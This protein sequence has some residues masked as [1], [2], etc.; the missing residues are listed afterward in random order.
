MK[1]TIEN[2]Y[3]RVVKATGEETDW[4]FSFLAF[5]D[6]QAEQKERMGFGK[7]YGKRKRDTKIRLYDRKAMRFPTGLLPILLA[8]AERRGFAVQTV[9]GRGSPHATFTELAD[10][11]FGMS[12]KWSFQLKALEAWA[13]GGD[14]NLVEKPLPFRGIVKS[15][16][17][18]GK[19]RIAVASAR[20]VEGHTL[21]MVHRGHLA[22][23]VRDRW[24]S[25]CT[26]LGEPHAGFIGDGEWR[27]GERL[28]CATLQT[29][30]RN[31]NIERYAKLVESVTSVVVDECHT[32]PAE[33]FYATIQDFDN[34]RTR[35]G[36][37]GTPYDRGDKRS[38]I[39]VA[40][41]GPMV[42]KIGA[43]QLIDLGVLSEPK[44]VVVP[45]W[46]E[47][48][49]RFRGDWNP[50]YRELVVESLHRNG[51]ILACM[52]KALADGDT[53][54]MVFV[55]RVGHAREL[56]KHAEKLGLNC[57][58]VDG[59]KDSKQRQDALRRL[60]A[61][62]LDFIVATKV[63]AEGVNIPELRCVINGAGGKSV[64]EVLQQVGRGTRTT[65]TKSSFVV[66]EVGDKGD[67]IMHKHARARVA[68]CQ[69][70]GYRCEV[71]TTIWPEAIDKARLAAYFARSLLEAI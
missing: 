23:D 42:Y 18:S 69:R 6:V 53:S 21:F 33:S 8:G 63:F 51:L 59:S 28:T 7:R 49:P 29:L 39:A 40:A 31:R 70:E 10:A 16:T 67:P 41:L 57:A 17:G 64:I 66:Y 14:G 37:S 4:L 68:A 9:D 61:G 45:C 65:E 25:L 50:T 44:I 26:S 34:A 54:G 35:L 46:Q 11:P 30:H 5:D 43:R 15:T 56:V 32:A 36:L 62:R 12:G 13:A 52:Q 55:R 3:T 71:D 1:I 2:S 24:D 20:A 38:L 19:G 27:E 58:Y 60:E 47:V 22:I 48:D